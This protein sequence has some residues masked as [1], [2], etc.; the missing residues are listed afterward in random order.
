MPEGHKKEM[1]QI[2]TIQ[3]ELDHTCLVKTL[4]VSEKNEPADVLVY[5]LR[6][7]LRMHT[8]VQELC[9]GGDLYGYLQ[10]SCNS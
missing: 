7:R 4:Y 9:E 5:P 8:I 2:L 10:V 3:K 1:R 6:R